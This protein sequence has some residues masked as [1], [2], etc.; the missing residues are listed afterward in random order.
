MR[1]YFFAALMLITTA[2]SVF[3]AGKHASPIR[4]GLIEGMSAPFEHAGAAAARNLEFAIEQVNARGGVQLPDGKHKLALSI[5]DGR[6]NVNE[7]LAQFRL[8]T[9]Q[10]IPFLVQG[11]NSEVASAL[12]DAVNRHNAHALENRLLFLSYAAVDPA[13]TNHQCSYWHFSFDAHTGMRM[14]ALTEAIRNDGQIKRVYLI[15]QD[16]G[17]GR[18]IAKAARKQLAA[19]RKDIDIVGDELHPA[20][21]AANFTSHIERI[22]ASGA[23]TVI[24]G[25]AGND[26]VLLVRGAVDAGLDLKFY[27]LFGNE[28]GAPAA[29][30]GAGIGRV[31]TVAEWHSNVG[32]SM[33]NRSSDIF[34]TA[35]RKR[36]PEPAQDHVHFRVH[37]MIEMLVA[38]IEKARTTEAAAV[39]HAL[40]GATFQNGFHHAT[41]RAADHQLIQPLY[42]SVMRRMGEG[43]VR[44]DAEGSGS[45]FMTERYIAES[46]TALP[47]T[48]R[49]ARPAG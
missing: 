8:L 9:G 11:N 49:M 48:C 25:S 44:Y 2:G 33:T 41:M 46:A 42:V 19:K 6:Q 29:I 47:T 45:G 37:L 43:S 5:F 27:T 36:Y 21:I 4:I 35:F 18:L 13:L 10:H 3:S 24:T 31:R 12:A 14:H 16:H 26:L 40:E 38:A 30:G 32:G 1:K 34:Y 15:A 17:T 39:A 28:P 20:G 22:R 23:D 7:S